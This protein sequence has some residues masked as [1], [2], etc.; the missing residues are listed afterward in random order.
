MPDQIPDP[1]NPTPPAADAPTIPPAET[2]TP[3]L[4]TPAPPFPTAGG[5]AN[6][7]IPPAPPIVEAP[8]EAPPGSAAPTFDIS[9]PGG[10]EPKKKFG[11]KKVFATILGVLVLVGGLGAGIIL[12]QQQQDIRQRAAPDCSTATSSLTCAAL[13]KTC[14]WDGKACQSVSATPTKAP[15][16][17]PTKAPEPTKSPTGTKCIADEQCQ[18]GEFCKEGNCVASTTSPTKEPTKGPS[19]TNCPFPQGEFGHV[20]DYSYQC[21]PVCPP[22][23]DGKAICTNGCTCPQGSSCTGEELPGTAGTSFA[24]KYCVGPGAG[25]TTPTIARATP[26]PGGEVTAQCL[27]IRAFDTEWNELTTTQLAQ[28]AAGDRVRFTVAG[29][30]SSGTFDRARFKVNGVE[31]AEVTGKRPGTD[32]F[33]DEYVIPSGITSFTINAQIHHTTLGW[34]N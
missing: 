13:G 26:G 3:P 1:T 25:G 9:V 22:T 14:L 4:E 17:T 20:G 19:P 18:A 23:S 34:S 11:G 10:Q 7:D 30:A 29:T 2:T 24:S 8:A 21:W 6:S 5:I 31:R 32:E 12:V 33:Y 15:T 16:A 28:L 27:N